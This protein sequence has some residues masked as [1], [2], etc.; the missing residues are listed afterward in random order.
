MLAIAIAPLEIC[1]SLVDVVRRK[2]TNKAAQL[3]TID[4]EGQNLEAASSLDDNSLNDI[5][6][7][8]TE[9]E[10]VDERLLGE[11]SMSIPPPPPP[12]PP[13]SPTEPTTPPEPSEPT[14]PPQP[15]T[16]GDCLVGT[17]R[18]DYLLN[19][20]TAITDPGLLQDLSTPQ[21][22]AFEFL[23]NDDFDPCTYPSIEQRFGLSV[24]YYSTAG[25]DWNE[26]EGWVQKGV[27]E[28][29][30]Y[31]VT[32][33]GDFV[34]GVQLGESS[35]VRVWMNYGLLEYVLT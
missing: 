21:G 7:E 5:W 13:P 25:D 17:T 20:L 8:A 32:C 6:D 23:V 10:F 2:R 29:E 33:G 14:T 16:P 30:W 1:A 3:F 12:P 19:L 27:N 31:N 18:E 15:T 26:N 22:A 9:L 11:F 4:A 35:S 28:C 34:I 24:F